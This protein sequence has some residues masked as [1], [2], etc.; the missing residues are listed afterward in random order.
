[1]GRKVTVGIYVN[2]K[3]VKKAREIGLNLSKIS[4]NALKKAIERLDKVEIEESGSISDFKMLRA[5][6]EPPRALAREAEAKRARKG[7]RRNLAIRG[8]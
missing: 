3:I 8:C 5:G 1:M 4:E 6:F 7:W 2:E